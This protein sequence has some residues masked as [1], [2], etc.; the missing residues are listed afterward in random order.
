[1]D[2]LQA[3]ALATC[4][5]SKGSVR[6]VLLVLLIRSRDGICWP[7]V[8]SIAA[9]TG[10]STRR[11]VDALAKLRQMGQIE[12]RKVKGGLN[13]YRILLK[14]DASQDAGV[15]R[16]GQRE[17]EDAGSVRLRTRAA[18]VSSSGLPTEGEGN[19]KRKSEKKER[20]AKRGGAPLYR[21]DDFWGLY[22]KKKA[23]PDAAKAWQ[24]LKADDPMVDKILAAIERQ[25]LSED[26][27]EAGGKFIP[28]PATWLNGRRWEDQISASYGNN[29]NNKTAAGVG[30]CN[31]AWQEE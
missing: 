23:K 31:A 28:Y 25:K 27:T 1:M 19:L 7:S 12:T 2:G 10:L 8:A 9:D 14:P 18:C 3:L 16:R 6:L 29:G 13:Q 4:S 26:W 22:P 5:P 11:V 15:S 17:T 30:R 20:A 21:F 24:K